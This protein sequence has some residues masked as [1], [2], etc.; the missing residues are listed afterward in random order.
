MAGA[1]LV[2]APPFWGEAPPISAVRQ[3]CDTIAPFTNH[4]SSRTIPNREI[5]SRRSHFSFNKR[6]R[7]MK[8]REKKQKK[9]DRRLARRGPSSD[10][11]ATETLPETEILRNVHSSDPGE[12]GSET[13]QSN[14]ES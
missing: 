14:E 2:A 10:G 9:Q 3:V 1:A 13:R 8:Q 11:I 5:M 12:D 4:W 6:Q 7:E